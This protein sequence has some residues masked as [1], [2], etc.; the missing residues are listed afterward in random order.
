MKLASNRRGRLLLLGSL[1]LLLAEWCWLGLPRYEGRSVAYWFHEFHRT[2]LGQRQPRGRHVQRAIQALGT[3]AVP[4][5]LEQVFK[6]DHR[7]WDIRLWHRAIAWSPWLDQTAPKGLK[8]YFSERERGQFD[9]S[10]DATM[11]LWH[12]HPPAP[13]LLP[14]LTNHLGDDRPQARWQA[15]LLLGCLDASVLPYLKPAFTNQDVYV[16]SAA[17]R[18]LAE[19]GPNAAGAVP[20]LIATFDDPLVHHLLSVQIL[21]RIGAPARLALPRLRQLWRSETNFHALA[22]IIQIADEAWAKEAFR[23]SLHPRDPMLRLWALRYLEDHHFASCPDQSPPI[24]DG[25]FLLPEL[26]SAA[27]DGEAEVR[28]HALAALGRLNLDAT[29]LKPLLEQRLR[30]PLA[31]KNN[32]DTGWIEEHE[33]LWASELLLRCDPGNAVALDFLA[34]RLDGS[35]AGEAVDILA[36]MEPPSPPGLEIIQRAT[37]HKDRAVREQA[38]EV[39]G[40]FRG[41]SRDGH[42]QGSF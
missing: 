21:H 28:F 2:I 31:I 35:Q 23:Q 3:N 27:G 33:R 24:A 12:L 30:Q 25:R 32:G 1:V 10:T 41:I 36:R 18:A 29:V 22:A 40:E 4:Y 39:L 6:A 19:L 42:R 16:R 9:P 13:L 34:E 5:L 15:I 7:S 38:I 14:T 8:E 26:L 17:F 11:W 37:R 20:D